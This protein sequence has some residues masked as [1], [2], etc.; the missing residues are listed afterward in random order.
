MSNARIL[1]LVNAL[2][3]C[4]ANL[5]A[6]LAELARAVPEDGIDS[7]RPCWRPSEGPWEN[8]TDRFTRT[9]PNQ[10][11]MVGGP[12]DGIRHPWWTDAE[13]REWAFRGII[14]PCD[15]RDYTPAPAV[16]VPPDGAQACPNCG[17]PNTDHW[18]PGNAN[19]CSSYTCVSRTLPEEPAPAVGQPA[20]GRITLRPGQTV[21]LHGVCD[22][23]VEAVAAPV[24]PPEPPRD[25]EDFDD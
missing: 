14:V 16:V 4:G 3:P 9:G 18:V 8:G 12:D 24:F 17:E 5:R 10:Y 2:Q 25:D 11:I 22:V 15:D 23:L 21:Y 1:S 20:I 7:P 6:I 13:V 19:I